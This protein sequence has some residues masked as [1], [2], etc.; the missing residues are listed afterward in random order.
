MK[1]GFWKRIWKKVDKFFEDDVSVDSGDEDDEIST[2]AFLIVLVV[3]IVIIGVMW[4]YMLSATP[5]L[6]IKIA[7]DMIDNER[8]EAFVDLGV[9]ESEMQHEGWYGWSE[10]RQTIETSYNAEDYL[11]EFGVN[12][13]SG[14]YQL[15]V[16][17]N[18]KENVTGPIIKIN[19]FDKPF[20][21]GGGRKYND[22]PVYFGKD[23]EKL[24]K[25]GDIEFGFKEKYKT[26]EFGM[27]NVVL[28]PGRYIIMLDDS[29]V[30]KA[31]FKIN[32]I[33]I[34]YR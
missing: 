30:N 19:M 13:R 5:N 32:K 33:G 14:R 24:I 4:W 17:L 1:K 26:F 10:T 6:K 7:D 18:L 29:L 34:C 8:C 27:K 2:R 28:E 22:V 15:G 21:D 9:K 23:P 25:I 16:G 12:E 20:V 11:D 3:G 31:H